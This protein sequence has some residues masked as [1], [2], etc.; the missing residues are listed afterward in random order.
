MEEFKVKDSGKRQEYKSGM[1]RDTQD[2]KPDYTLIDMTFLKRLAAHMT[3]G[4]KKYGRR[5]WQNANSE[6]ELE[7]FKSS[8]LRHMMQWLAGEEEEDH[9]AAVAFNLAAAE[10]VKEKLRNGNSS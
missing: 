3:K 1:V 9:M 6:E 2:D 5:N 8:A 7:R 4:A 10:Y